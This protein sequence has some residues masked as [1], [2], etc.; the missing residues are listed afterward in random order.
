LFVHVVINIFVTP[1]ALA[2][3]IIFF[4]VCISC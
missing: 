3:F 4:P 2:I 1:L